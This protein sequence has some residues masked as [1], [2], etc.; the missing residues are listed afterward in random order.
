VAQ[1]RTYPV[2][3]RRISISLLAVFSLLLIGLAY[4]FYSQSRQ[5]KESPYDPLIVQVAHETGV[6][7]FLIRALIWR[8][9]RFKPDTHGTAD[10][11]GLMQVTP[12]VG[13]MWAK[14][15]KIAVFQADDLYDP[16]TNIRAGTW[17][18][19]RALKH[20]SQTDDPVSF[21]LAEYNAGR[22]NAYK[23]VD[24]A[25]PQNHLAFIDR[26][27]YPGTR[28]YVEV[29]LTQ[30]AQYRTQLAKDRWY[31]EFATPNSAVT[32]SP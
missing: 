20:W 11:R 13:S 24:P 14:A 27:T 1:V 10:E 31:R 6:D 4:L 3:S 17:Y 22:S 12:E 18:L 28:K 30:R 7:P 23:W 16:L 32:V 21:A 29:I 25:D 2:P 15:S 19:N 26:I 5:P 8:E 9:S